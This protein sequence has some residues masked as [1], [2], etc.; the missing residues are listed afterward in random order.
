MST[1]IEFNK[2]IYLSQAC[3]I[4]CNINTLIG[5]FMHFVI[6]A[7]ALEQTHFVLDLI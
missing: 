6:C 3:F 5:N 1:L 2:K 7:D 4:L